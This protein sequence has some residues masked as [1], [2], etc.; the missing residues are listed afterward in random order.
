MAT[1]TQQDKATALHSALSA[2]QMTSIP[3]MSSDRSIPRKDQAK[4][5][6][7]LFKRLGLKGIS[8]TTPSYSMAQGVEI[9]VPKRTDYIHDERQEIDYLTDPASQANSKAARDVQ[10]ILARAFPQ[11]DDRSET[12]SDYFNYCWSID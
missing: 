5:A 4:L 12:Q 2:V 6:R 8:V 3:T 7:Q 1:A 10:E 11:H 9:M